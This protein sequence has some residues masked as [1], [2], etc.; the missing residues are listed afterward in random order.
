MSEN[1]IVDKSFDFAV[2]IVN[3]NKYLN[4]EQKEYILS[5]QLLRSGTSIGANV[6]EAERAQSKADFISK[7]SIALKEA[8]ETNYWLKLLYKTDYLNKSQYD[9]INTD[10]NELISILIAICKTSNSS[11]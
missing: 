1:I 8:N 3:L 5:K 7:M 6:S 9:S 11:K 10:I 2:R 4:N